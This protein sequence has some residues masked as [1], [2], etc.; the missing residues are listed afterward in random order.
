MGGI[1]FV[2]CSLISVFIMSVVIS[3][4][5]S[6][7]VKAI[8]DNA[9]QV[10]ATEIAIESYTNDEGDYQITGSDVSV[11]DGYSPY[12]R[13]KDIMSNYGFF[14]GASNQCDGNIRVEWNSNNNTSKL[15][16]C[17]FELNSGDRIKPNEQTAIIEN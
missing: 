2:I 14:Q 11:A 3:L 10:V 9:A 8:S 1:F 12:S 13:F 6:S 5:Q 17:G 4:S 16:M 7:T 15:Y